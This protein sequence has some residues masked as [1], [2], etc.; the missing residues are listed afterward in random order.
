MFSALNIVKALIKYTLIVGFTGGFVDMT[1][2]MFGQA[3]VAMKSGLVNLSDLNMAL[4]S[5]GGGK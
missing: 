2:S 5:D 1:L 4:F 3:S